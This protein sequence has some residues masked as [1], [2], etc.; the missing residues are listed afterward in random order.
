MKCFHKAG[1]GSAGIAFRSGH[2]CVTV[3]VG[4]FFA[5]LGQVEANTINAANPSLAAVSTAIALAADGDTVIVPAGIAAWTGQLNI[6]NKSIA[7]LGPESPDSPL[8]GTGQAVITDSTNKAGSTPLLMRWTTKA[9]GYP[10]ISGIR[11]QGGNVGSG[12]F[13]ILE[14]RGTTPQ[15]RVDHCRFTLTNCQAIFT[16]EYVRGVVDHC[17][18]DQTNHVLG[19]IYAFHNIW[20][21]P[22]SDNGDA[23]WAAPSSLGTADA[24]FY[25]DCTWNNP[26][27]NLFCYGVDG[28]SGARVVIRHCTLNNVIASNHGTESGGRLRGARQYE[29]YE[30]DT[31]SSGGGEAVAFSA[32]SGCGVVFNNRITRTGSGVAILMNMADFRVQNSEFP[33]LF[34]PFCFSGSWTI[35]SLTRSGT[36]VTVTVANKTLPGG[37]T[38]HGL[39]NGIGEYV[40]IRGCNQSDYNGIFPLGSVLNST[41]FTYQVTSSQ[42]TTG[43]GT[44]RYSQPWDSNTDQ[45][46]ANV[47]DAWGYPCLDQNGW[48]QGDLLSGWV[49]PLWNFVGWPHQIMEGV[50]IWGNTINGSPTAPT[51]FSDQSPV[52]KIGREIFL[53]A[54]PG[55]T[56]YAYPH[57]LVGGAAPTPTPTPPTAPANLRIT[58][59]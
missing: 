52:A 40:R 5:L 6:T 4:I 56:P 25:E 13:G 1:P 8:F 37:V 58:G 44:M 53:S 10:R 7:I 26:N 38:G 59:P 49:S 34:P 16:M 23:S 45:D 41:Q 2:L 32:R 3:V 47:A 22:G 17:Y 48:G 19:A 14:F 15:L 12:S 43:T 54:K 24:I 31:L 33:N 21:V 28:W 46:A 29:Y 11:F 20:N 9:T 18:F 55:Y 57:P 42:A 27:P 51:D 35:T 36:T 30:N 50:Y 39:Q